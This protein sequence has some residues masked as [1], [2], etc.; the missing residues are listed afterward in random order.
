MSKQESSADELEK[1][2]AELQSTRQR[3]AE[4]EAA[5]AARES[6]ASAKQRVQEELQRVKDRLA[7]MEELELG[8]D[9]LGAKLSKAQG[10]ESGFGIGCIACSS[11]SFA[12]VCPVAR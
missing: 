4:L 7:C 12:Q 2:M 5:K 8:L 9:A 11:V 10:Y 6:A 1:V 3:I